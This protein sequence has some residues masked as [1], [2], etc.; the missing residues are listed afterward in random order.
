[1]AQ[2]WRWGVGAVAVAVLF[3]GAVQNTDALTRTDRQSSMQEQQRGHAE[4]QKISG[5]VKKTKHVG[6][7]GR[8]QENLV[9]QIQTTQGGKKIVDLGN[10]EHVE[11]LDIQKGD[12]IT[13]WGRSVDIGDKR[14]FMAHKIKANDETVEIERQQ[15]SRQDSRMGRSGQSQSSRSRSRSDEFERTAQSRDS[16]MDY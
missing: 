16:D 8:D 14:V 12:R 2:A 10:V 15:M 6:L 9:V 3:T 11:D 4:W 5:T 13:A 7:R 1:M